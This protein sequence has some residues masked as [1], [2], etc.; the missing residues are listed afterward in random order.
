[1]ID[2]AMINLTAVGSMIFVGFHILFAIALMDG[3][4]DVYE[5]R[6]LV[7]TIAAIII[8]LSYFVLFEGLYGAT[9]VNFCWECT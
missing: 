1:M 8:S 3:D 6:D 2:V 9:P 5:G 4:V 7:F